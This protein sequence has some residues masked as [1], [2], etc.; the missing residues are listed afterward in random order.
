LKGETPVIFGDGEQSR[1][2]T[3][4]ANVVDAV[5]RASSAPGAPGRPINVGVGASF[6]LNQTIALLNRIFGRDVVPRYAP[7][8]PGDVLHSRADLALARQLLGYEPKVG[9]EQGLR[10]TVQWYRSTLLAE[11]SAV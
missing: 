6:T 9:F 7:P 3:Y 8:R 4:V 10:E 5:L 2:F 1:D 11:A